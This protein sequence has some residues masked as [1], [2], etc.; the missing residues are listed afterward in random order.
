MKMPA[1]LESSSGRGRDREGMVHPEI[2]GLDST[3]AGLPLE[4]ARLDEIFTAQYPRLIQFLLGAYKV[5]PDLAEDIVQSAYARLAGLLDQGKIIRAS[6]PEA[7]FKKSVKNLLLNYFERSARHDV[8]LDAALDPRDRSQRQPI[9]TIEAREKLAKAERSWSELSDPERKLLT[10]IDQDGHSLK[11]AAARLELPYKAA[12]TA[13]QR[14]HKKLRLELGRH[15]STFI[16]PADGDHYA[17]R[18]RKAMLA[19]IDGLPREHRELLQARLVEALPE[20]A[21]AARLDLGPKELPTR[22]EHALLLLERKTGLGREEI[23]RA[24][25]KTRGS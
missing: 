13:Y 6:D 9:S 19:E 18:G 4:R 11:E 16:L 7:F 25:E 1:F 20:D 23:R 3:D 24:L 15:W 22:F 2:P 8:P 14:A 10:L 5:E 17:P 21:A 12:A